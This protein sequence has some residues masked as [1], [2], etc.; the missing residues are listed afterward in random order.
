MTRVTKSSIYKHHR[1]T[2]RRPR[3][4]GFF[5]WP[6]IARDERIMDNFLERLGESERREAEATRRILKAA[7]RET[8]GG[9][10]S[11]SAILIE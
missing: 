6:E 5:V 4:D 2:L 7:F 11:D 3:T 10:S 1:S 8:V 9:H